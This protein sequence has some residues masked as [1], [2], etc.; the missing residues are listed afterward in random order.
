MDA[1]AM[2]ADRRRRLCCV[3]AKAAEI[4]KV[5][6]VEVKVVE[7]ALVVK[8]ALVQ[9]VVITRNRARARNVEVGPTVAVSI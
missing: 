7:E 8:E 5:K 3:V 4:V 1:A 2:V 9:V 6:V